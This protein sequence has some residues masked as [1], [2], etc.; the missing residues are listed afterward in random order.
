MTGRE[1]GIM[2]KN[3]CQIPAN[4]GSHT[5]KAWRH[6]LCLAILFVIFQNILLSYYS[7]H[8][9]S[10]LDSYFVL[11]RTLSSSVVGA[12]PFSNI[13]N[14]SNS[15]TPKL[16]ILISRTVSN[17]DIEN[18]FRDIDS[19]ANEESSKS[20]LY[21]VQW[22]L[23]CYQEETKIKLIDQKR[24]R[25]SIVDIHIIFDQG[26]KLHFWQ[27]YLNPSDHMSNNI[28]Y[29]WMIDGDISLAHMAWGC[30]WDI[31]VKHKPLIS[32]PALLKGPAS[33]R[34]SPWA[35]LEY[36]K[37]CEVTGDNGSNEKTTDDTTRVGL[38]RLE[39]AEVGIIEVGSPLFTSLAWTAIYETFTEQIPNWGERYSDYGPDQVWC[40]L[41]DHKVNNVTRSERLV[42][43]EL[44]KRHWL[45]AKSRCYI[46]RVEDD[47]IM[48][49][50]SGSLPPSCMVIHSTPI[51]HLDTKSLSSTLGLKHKAS[52]VDLHY[53]KKVFKDYDYVNDLQPDGN[54]YIYKPRFASRRCQKCKRYACY[55]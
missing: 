45:E 38:H 5:S 2:E 46:D 41:V 33:K 26:H 48:G 52:L 20:G 13:V 39:V 36:P 11:P 27:Q 18:V 1:E 34:Q 12:N 25:R 8:G 23:F 3:F 50:N 32:Q 51:P 55:E 30:F 53:Y 7:Y 35:G 49:G 4:N 24:Q 47:S 16:T 31:I 44:T 17:H 40:N 6:L 22:K 14:K 54:R 9:N 10:I 21:K 43:Q 37:K 29:F 28:D 42:E 15:I 19:I